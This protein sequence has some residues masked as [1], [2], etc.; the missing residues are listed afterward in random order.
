MRRHVQAYCASSG[1]LPWT[2]LC[3]TATVKIDEERTT[4]PSPSTNPLNPWG[5]DV[6]T[7]GSVTLTPSPT[8]DVTRRTP[9]CMP[10]AFDGN[11][12]QS[13]PTSILCGTLLLCSDAL[14]PFT[15][16]QGVKL[17]V[18]KENPRGPLGDTS[19]N[20]EVG[21]KGESVPS[22]GSPQPY[23][24]A[25]LFTLSPGHAP[26]LPSTVTRI[27]PARAGAIVNTRARGGRLSCIGCKTLSSFR[28]RRS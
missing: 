23:P 9:F 8:L 7:A 14:P 18:L 15:V 28:P 10:E 20:R 21:P 2:T 19:T 25:Q 6:M 5:I 17:V 1:M 12:D 11:L 16:S 26:L 4:T 3:E 27:V 22:T 24:F 13:T